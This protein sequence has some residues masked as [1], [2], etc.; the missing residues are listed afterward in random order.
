MYKKERPIVISIIAIL[1]M[2]GGALVILLG[3][4]FLVLSLGI[5]GEDFASVWEDTFA[6]TFGAIFGVLAVGILF[7]GFLMFILGYG[8]WKLNLAAWFVSVILYGLSSISTV[9]S[10]QTIL[11]SVQSNGLSELLYPMIPVGLFIYF[12]VVKDKF[13]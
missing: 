9:M 7:V 10:Y 1:E 11:D 4:L 12:L 5:L 6:A 2:L 8:L 3:G 13:N